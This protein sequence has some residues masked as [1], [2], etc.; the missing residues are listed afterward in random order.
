MST[1][2]AG[3]GLS[4]GLTG[5]ALQQVG[6]R[7]RGFAVGGPLRLSDMA[8]YLVEASVVVGGGQPVIGFQ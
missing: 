2:L 5:V 3:Y 4:L 6:Y 1:G 7:C 8:E